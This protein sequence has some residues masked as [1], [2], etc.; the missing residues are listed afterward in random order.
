MMSMTIVLIV[1][2]VAYVLYHNDAYIVQGNL[3][4]LPI[5]I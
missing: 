3:Y 1:N 5:S 4:N 2:P